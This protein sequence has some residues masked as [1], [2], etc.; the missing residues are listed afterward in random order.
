[1]A[2]AKIMSLSLKV[3]LGADACPAQ[4]VQTLDHSLRWLQGN[5]CVS[6][7]H[8]GADDRFHGGLRP[9]RSLPRW[10]GSQH[11]LGPPEPCLFDTI[12][13]GICEGEA[14]WT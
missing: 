10:P 13:R 6:I 1:V 3:S 11:Y 9:G 2:S 5:T 4:R 14:L 12:A 7:L 8:P